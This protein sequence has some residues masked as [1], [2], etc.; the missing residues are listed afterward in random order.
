MGVFG[1]GPN[2][3]PIVPG[4]TKPYLGGF[5]CNIPQL[6]V[7]EGCRKDK[8]NCTLELSSLKAAKASVDGFA[9]AACWEENP[10]K[11]SGRGS[12]NFFLPS[13][14]KLGIQLVNSRLAKDSVS[15]EMMQQFCVWCYVQ[16]NIQ[17]TKW[18]SCEV[19]LVK[20]RILLISSVRCSIP[21]L[22]SHFQHSVICTIIS[23]WYRIH[24]NP[25]SFE[26]LVSLS[27]LH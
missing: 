7:V 1:A 18:N 27:K 3:S 4:I 12:N 10:Q 21:V 17:N 15:W 8:G 26:L 23:L 13:F 6:P 14:F 16:P 24:S 5:C 11:K 20:L 22:W 25:P 19:N 9:V 2:F